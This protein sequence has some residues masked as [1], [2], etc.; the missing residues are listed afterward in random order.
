MGG[1]SGGSGEPQQ[2]QTRSILNRRRARVVDLGAVGA[3]A[4]IKL[5][6]TVPNSLQFTE[7]RPSEWQL[8]VAGKGSGKGQLTKENKNKG[9]A[10]IALEG[11][12][13]VVEVESAVYYCEEEK[14]VCRSDGVI[15]RAEVKSGGPSEVVA[16]H[17]VELPTAAKSKVGAGV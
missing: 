7:T 1:G 2:P 12:S 14:G 17:L 10:T 9:S 8:V 16:A 13:G 3:K 11:G 15:F 6:V 5:Q 4:T